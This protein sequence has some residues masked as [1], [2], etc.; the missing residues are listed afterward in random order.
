VYIG[1]YSFIAGGSGNLYSHFEKNYLAIPL[2][3][4]RIYLPQ[5]P[6]I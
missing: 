4:L 3:K 6:A 5:D 2:K 1:E